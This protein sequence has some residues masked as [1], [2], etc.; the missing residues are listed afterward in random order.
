M[1]RICFENQLDMFEVHLRKTAQIWQRRAGFLPHRRK[2]MQD[3]G[4]HGRERAQGAIFR[5]EVSMR[6]NLVLL[7]GCQLPGRSR[8]GDVGGQGM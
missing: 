4:E 1:C 8:S 5:V 7:S 3:W 2:L 6:D